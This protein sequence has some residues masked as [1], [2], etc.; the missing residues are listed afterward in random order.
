MD[1]DFH[2]NDDDLRPRLVDLFLMFNIKHLFYE[3]KM[4]I[5][6]QSIL[7]EIVIFKKIFLGR[8]IFELF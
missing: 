3:I 5:F 6:S 8:I 1:D 7:C 4:R 2:M